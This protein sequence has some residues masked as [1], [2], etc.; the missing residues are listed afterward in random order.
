MSKEF[1]TCLFE[2]NES[3]CLTVPP[4]GTT[5]LSLSFVQTGF[6][7]FSI[8]PLNG[9]IDTSPTESWHDIHRPRRCDANVTAYR[10]ILVEMDGLSLEDQIRHISEIGMP[11]STRVYSG[12]KSYHFIISLITPLSSRRE[13]DALVRRVYKAVGRDKVDVTCKNPSRLSRVPGHLRE[14]TG[15]SQDLME[16]RERVEREVLEAWLLRRDVPVREDTDW[17]DIRTG[18]PK[19]FSSLNGFTQNF[20]MFGDDTGKWNYK[21]FRASADLCRNGWS[22]EEAE[23]ELQKITGILDANDL[24]TIK[25]AYRNEAQKGAMDG[26]EAKST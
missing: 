13:Y 23:I 6:C 12:S 16:V 14:D 15:R 7:Y 22:F 20:L 25:S 9:L 18:P 11:Y 8:N 5:V 26:K 17:E 1:W 3:T 19:Q 21:L 2:P 4:K 24:K 10:N